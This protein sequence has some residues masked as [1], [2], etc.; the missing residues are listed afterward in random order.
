M[1]NNRGWSDLI[2]LQPL[3]SLPGRGVRGMWAP[4]TSPTR[5]SLDAKEYIALS[6]VKN[7]LK[8]Q[9]TTG[10]YIAFVLIIKG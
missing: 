6:N 4:P 8:N 5:P 1:V 7:Q 2:N 9:E 3:S 10:A